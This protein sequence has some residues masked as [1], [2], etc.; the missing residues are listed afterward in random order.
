VGTANFAARTLGVRQGQASPRSVLHT[1]A[2]PDARPLTSPLRALWLLVCL[3]VG[4][5]AQG[6]DASHAAAQKLP[7]IPGGLPTENPWRDAQGEDLTVGLVTF[8]PGDDVY[9]YFGHNAVIVQDRKQE[10][11]RLYNYG[12]FRFGPDM[13]PSYM[14]GQLTFWVGQ[15]P[16]HATFARYIDANRSVR[17]QE[18]NLSPAARLRLAQGLGEAVLP[19]N[20]YYLYHHYHNNCSTKLRDLLDQAIGGQ[21][22]RALSRP[23]RLNHRQ[24]TRRYA[25]QDPIVDFML[26]FWMN[27]QME[28]PIEAWDELFLP[29]ELE[30]QVARMQYVNERGER[31]PLVETSYTVFEADRAPTPDVPPVTWPYNL[32]LG[33]LLALVAWITARRMATTASRLARWAFGLQHMLVGLALGVPGLLGF[34]MWTLT[35]HDVTY[36][37]ENQWL[38]NPL[39][40]LALPLGA[41]IAFGSQRALRV[42][43]WA[44][45]ALAGM[46]VL[47]LVLKLLPNFD[48][49]IVLPMTLLLPLNFGYAWA[50]RTLLTQG[51]RA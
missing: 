36:H 49:D 42:A 3:S 30:L 50:H 48:Q 27:D 20:R 41:A 18:L 24:H 8:G 22:K 4:V 32:A 17:V 51:P 23:A 16:V 28:R 38:A 34:L 6:F 25:S 7:V 31:V 43:R 37:N 11:A 12:M 21:F 29:E 19:A 40:F 1:H 39:T 45:F 46:S 35:A 47:A 26:V 2:V 14:K 5:G 13:L 44:F 10:L 33:S 15:T 9:N